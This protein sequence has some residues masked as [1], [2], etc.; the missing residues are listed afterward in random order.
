MSSGKIGIFLPGQHGDIMSAMSVLKYKDVLWPDKDIVWFC[1]MPKAEVLKYGPIEVRHWPEGWG[2]PER[3][4]V[5]GPLAVSKGEPMWYDFSVLKTENNRLHQQLKHNFESTKDLDEGYFPAPWMLSVQAR[6]GIDYP[7][8]SRKIFGAD[9]SWEWHPFLSFS[10]EE[11]E[12]A[13]EF[14]AKLPYSKTI[15]METFMG[16]GQASW[17]D[18]MTA[19]TIRMC[20]ERL[21]SCN[22]IFASHTDNSKFMDDPGVVSCSHFSVRQTALVNNYADLFVGVGS[23][24][25]VATSCWGNKQT[26]KIQYTGSFIGSTKSLANGPFELIETDPPAANSEQKFYIKLNEML[27]KL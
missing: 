17:N 14:C 24:I 25:S 4:A 6:H 22:F 11:R 9:P 7:N 23:G 10:D 27:G 19:T 18:T 16:S 3:C 15:M 20:R 26:P 13:K 5:D 8:I 2:L 1:A 12:M 21:G